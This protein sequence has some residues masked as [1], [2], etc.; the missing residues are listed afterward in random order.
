VQGET[1]P[2]KILEGM[3]RV[4][5]EQW[6]EV[7]VLIRGG[8][9]IEDLWTFNDENLATA[10]LHSPIPVLAGIGHE[11]DFTLADMTADVRA[12]TPSHAAQ[13][14]WP[15]R[16]ELLRRVSELEKSLHLAERRY[17]D[18]LDLRLRGLARDLE[19]RSPERTLAAWR[20]RL[21]SGLR[22]LRVAGRMVLE[23]EEARLTICLSALMSVPGRIPLKTER[24][25]VLEGRLAQSWRRTLAAGETELQA[26]LFG[27]ARMPSRL[28]AGAA[29][30]EALEGRLRVQAGRILAD[31]RHGLDRAALRLEALNPYAPLE[32]G[33]GLLR[34]SDG[35]LVTSVADAA[36]GDALRVT[37]RDGDIPVRVEG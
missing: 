37:V 35:A 28:P 9:S 17:S 1:A 24:L 33:Y 11:V 12:A 20:E 16:D 8:G 15:P 26:V 4:F 31:A 21:S 29:A 3:A 25:S 18:T 2:Q 7:L 32:R 22:L 14:L 19:W 6:A 36:P 23:R 34:R 5:A 13:L 10:V 30:L 27:L